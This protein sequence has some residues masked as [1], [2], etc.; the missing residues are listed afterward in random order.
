VRLI[1]AVFHAAGQKEMQWWKSEITESDKIS[2]KIRCNSD[3]THIQEMQ[4]N[5]NPKSEFLEYF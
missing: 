5:P 2:K 4:T 3:K 1:I